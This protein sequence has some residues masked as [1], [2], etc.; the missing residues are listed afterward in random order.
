[1]VNINSKKITIWA[2]ALISCVYFVVLWYP[3]SAASQDFGMVEIFE[4]DEAYP[5]PYLLDMIKPQDSLGQTIRN[6]VDYEYYFYGFPYFVY[7]A[8]TILPVKLLGGIDQHIPT[9]MV[10][11]RQMVSLLPLLVS[12]ILLVYMQTGFK[13]HWGK[14]I[15]LFIFMLLVP[16]V[17][18]NNFWWHPDGLVIFFIVLT[19]FFLLKDNFDFGK[20]FKLAALACA[21]ATGTKTIGL[22][23]FLTI[24]SYLIWGW[25]VKRINLKQM[26]LAGL[27]FV[28]ILAA[29]IVISNPQLLFETPRNGIIFTLKAQSSFISSGFEVLYA[30]GLSAAAP[31]LKR[32]FGGFIFLGLAFLAPIFGMI[33]NRN[34]LLH[35]LILT[36]SLP[37][38]IY[39]I[40]SII[41][42]FQYFLP[43]AIPLLSSIVVYFPNLDQIKQ[44]ITEGNS[45]KIAGILLSGAAF[46]V[47]VFQFFSNLIWS[48]PA[49]TDRL[50]REENSASIQF[51]TKVEEHLE[52]LLDVEL[53]AYRD[54]RLYV[55][56]H[57]A[58][59][60]FAEFKLLNYSY[61]EESKPAVILLMQQRLYDYLNPEVSGIEA[62][63]LEISRV[64]YAD[65]NQGDL[66]GY[67]LVF[68]DEFGLAFVRNDV[69]LEY[70]E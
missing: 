55:P 31:G 39:V 35:F 41:F 3:N 28:V 52:P 16:A 61:F 37:L 19:I 24:P 15:F 67:T 50:H 6:F 33:K 22:F 44:Q 11:L 59:I 2:I 56:D 1:M 66:D 36:W 45:K 70:F 12:I 51:Y 9:T 29:G 23:F 5:M 8:A 38:S 53:F 17:T 21:F 46:L 30:R 54:V 64:F 10:L 27:T 43:A 40:F 4:P 32:Y 7:S 60:T 47:I 26:L 25:W 58:W 65:A 48:V 68:R 69:Y 62:D 63:Q 13:Q 49:Y 20:F 34:R 42:K 14:T 57:S 18:M